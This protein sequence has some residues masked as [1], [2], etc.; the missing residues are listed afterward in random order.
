MKNT[1][2]QLHTI[3]SAPKKAKVRLEQ[4]EKSFGFIPNLYRMLAESPPVLEAYQAVQKLFMETS[5]SPVERNVVWLAT[6]YANRCHYCMAGHS[7]MAG[8]QGTPQEVIDAMRAGQPLAAPKLEALRMFTTQIVV[9]RGALS[10]DDAEK[11]LQAGFTRKNILE[12]VLGITQKTLSNY[13]NH[14][15]QTPVDK[16]FSSFEW[17]PYHESKPIT[18]VSSAMPFPSHYIEVKGSKM[19][20]L[21]EGEGRPILLLHGNPTSS[22]LWRNI[23]PYLTPHGRIVAV[24]LIG[25][26]KSDKPDI[27]YTFQ[28][29]AAYLEAFI[30]ALGMGSDLT[31][32]VHDWGSGLGFHYAANYPDAIRAVAFMEAQAAPVVPALFEH[33]PE[34]Q[35]ETFR[36]F[37]HPE[38]RELLLREQNMFIE[39]FLPQATMRPL[40]K[41]VHDIYR[42]PFE[43]P[44]LRTPLVVWPSQIPIDGE[45]AAMVEAANQWN[46]W[47]KTSPV[48]KLALYAEPGAFMLKQAVDAMKQLFPNLATQSIGPGLHFVPES[49][50]DAIGTALALWLQT[51]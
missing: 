47:L 3:E 18:P 4:T 9:Q 28:D 7:A 22:Y 6:I 17:T 13:A 37:R 10:T 24:D 34:E 36:A 31:L 12:V 32:V 14:F 23:I 1:D 51:N 43:I 11:F 30:D 35:A 5:L 20:Y 29:H 26:G 42:E 16:Q 15:A 33:I 8:S 27:G 46:N 38:T 48:P 44:A 39:Q 25:M 2:F 41:Q 21:D 40:S 19:H 45:P 49:Q 50:P